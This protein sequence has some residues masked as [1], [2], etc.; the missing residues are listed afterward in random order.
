RDRAEPDGRPLSRGDTPTMSDRKERRTKRAWELETLGQTLAAKPERET[1]FSTV[2]SLPID[3][4]AAPEDL[5]GWSAAEKLGF[6]G[7]Y[8]YT[9]GIHPTMYRG[10]LWTM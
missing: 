8:P 5:E 3:R 9:R 7:E 2:S 10:K 6:P 1:Q 4:L